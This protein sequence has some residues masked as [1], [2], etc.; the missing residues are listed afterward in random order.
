LA[1]NLSDQP[2][3]DISCIQPVEWFSTGRPDTL[4][5]AAQAWLG[6]KA[7]TQLLFI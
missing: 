1:G 7:E 5:A 6:L 4:D 2:L 3:R